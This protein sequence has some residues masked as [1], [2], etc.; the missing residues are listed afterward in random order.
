MTVRC[1]SLHGEPGQSELIELGDVATHAINEEGVSPADQAVLDF[2]EI[3]T[4]LNADALR[5]AA[6]KS[7][8]ITAQQN[9][10]F[11]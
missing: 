11:L 1:Y 3:D 9:G 6:T 2:Y 5:A 8:V 10:V 4:K 7:A